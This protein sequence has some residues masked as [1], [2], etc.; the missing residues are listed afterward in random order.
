MASKSWLIVVAIIVSVLQGLEGSI[1][2]PP[3]VLPPST[4]DSMPPIL[5]DNGSKEDTPSKAPSPTVEIQAPNF[6][7]G[8]GQAATPSN[9]ISPI[10]HIVKGKPK[11]GDHEVTHGCTPSPLSPGPAVSPV[12]FYPPIT[13][14]SQ[15]VA[16]PPM[17]MSHHLS[18][19]KKSPIPG[20][21]PLRTPRPFEASDPPNNAPSK[22]KT[23]QPF[24]C[25]VKFISSTIKSSRTIFLSYS[26]S[27]FSSSE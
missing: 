21:S 10:S 15:P 27:I 2:H 13:R 3:M 9:A 1:L 17:V 18:P 7:T 8:A 20:F 6:P 24:T 5:P 12:L 14:N 11:S 23:Q 16:A 19:V 4:Q 26:I 22:E 25:S